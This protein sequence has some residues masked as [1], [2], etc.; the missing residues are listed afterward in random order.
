MKL[1]AAVPIFFFLLV[2]PAI[3]A[4]PQPDPAFQEKV[5]GRWVRPDGGYVIHVREVK[6]DGSVDAG[7]FNP[8]EIHVSVA[9][10]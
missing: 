8:E 1:L 7:Y 9:N 6:P 2:F 10:V 3:A 5:V 4:E